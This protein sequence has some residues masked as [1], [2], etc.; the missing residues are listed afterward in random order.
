MS[1]QNRS[2]T[3]MIGLPFRQTGRRY[4]VQTWQDICGIRI[5]V[6]LHKALFGNYLRKATWQGMKLALLSN[7]SWRRCYFPSTLLQGDLDEVE[8]TGRSI[9]CPP[10]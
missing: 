6:I 1:G 9:D 8:T 3:A 7:Q 10:L 4:P 2:N 5:L